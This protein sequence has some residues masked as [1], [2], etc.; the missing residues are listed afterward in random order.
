MY[1]PYYP[2]QYAV[3][4]ADTLGPSLD[5]GVD[6]PQI[7]KMLESRQEVKHVA[8]IFQEYGYS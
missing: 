4:R 8:E 6:T 3:G 5:C 1:P 7:F 2:R